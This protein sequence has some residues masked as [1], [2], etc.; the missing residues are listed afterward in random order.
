MLVACWL[1]AC[2]ASTHGAITADQADAGTS[3]ADEA[4]DDFKGC[5][6][7]LPAFGPGLRAAGDHY[8]LKLLAATP[9]QPERYTE[10]DWTV[11]LTTL[12]GSS[13]SDAQIVHGQ[14]FMP[15]HGHDGRVEPGVKALAT[16]GQFQ[17]DR[18]N[19]SMRGPW[20]VRLWLDSASVAEDRLVFQVCVTK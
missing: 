11:E 8:A 9:D 1:A 14:T 17:V 18:L 7:E 15:L 10:N 3:A 16:A 5:P 4:D 20:E 13:T 2:S 6:T 19:F 12:D